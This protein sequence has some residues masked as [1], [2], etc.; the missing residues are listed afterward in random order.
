M[1]SRYIHGSVTVLSEL[2]EWIE[3]LGWKTPCCTHRTSS[4]GSGAGPWNP[5]MSQPWCGKPDRPIP[6]IVAMLCRNDSHEVELSPAQL[7]A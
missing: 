2:T 3:N 6:R 4:S 1:W 5:P 7:W